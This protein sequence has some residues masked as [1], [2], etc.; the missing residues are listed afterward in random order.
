MNGILQPL[1]S[2]SQTTSPPPLASYSSKPY[3]F[4]YTFPSPFKFPTTCSSLACT[5]STTTITTKLTHLTT[6]A[7]SQ[8]QN[9]LYLLR[10]R[11]TEE[12]WELYSNLQHLPN[13]TCLS[14]LVSQLSFQ[15]TISGLKRAQSIVTRL[16]HERQLHRLDANCL[17]LLAVAASNAGHTLYAASVLKSMLRSGYLPNVKAW[18]AVVSRLTS[19]DDN[20]PA[21]ALRLFKGVTRRLRKLS[22]GGVVAAASMPDTAAFNA[23]LNACANLGDSNM[24]LQV[25]NEMPQY[26][27]VPDAFSYNIL[28][29][30]CC[31]TG[32]KHLLVYVLERILQ[33]GIP[34]C[35]TTLH[36]IV[37]SYVDLGDLETAE[38]LVQAM[39]EG[40]RDL[41]RIIREREREI[42]LNL[43]E[44]SESDDN[45]ADVDV[46]NA[47]AKLLPNFM[48]SNSCND[49]PV[50]PKAY[51][52]NTRMY[53][54]LM[55]GYMKA[56][57][58]TDTVRM[59]EAMRR[60]DDAGSHPDHV[61]YTTVVSA[62]V[63]AGYMD[64]ARQVLAEMM[65]IGVAANRITY[66]VLLKGYCNQF[67]I[68]KARELIKEMVDDRG[69]QPDVVSYNILID[70]CILVDDSAGALGFFNEMRTRGIAP[71]KIS[72]T[73]LM[74]AFAFSG[75]PKLAHK[76]FDEMLNDP[77]VKVDVIAWN[78]LV[79]G[80]CRLGLVEEAK[81]VI[82]K[83]KDEGFHPD[84]GTY[85]SFA[86]GIA[87]ARRPGEALL[88][89]NEV[90][91]RWEMV[92]KGSKHNSCVPPLKPDEGLLD[93]LAD[94]CVRAAFFRKALEIVACMEENGI[95]PNKTKFTR[96][97][98]EMHSRMFTSKHASRAR[99]DR[100]IERRR[101]AEAFKFWLG[102]PNSYYGSEWRL[103]PI[104]GYDDTAAS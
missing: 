8:D 37:A 103:E 46:E 23:V 98:V 79:E 9:L 93:T 50:L 39:R 78:M 65:R 64:R 27:V 16:R 61:S 99:Q 38:R 92:K 3:P 21:E 56:G 35:V 40:R 83:M 62:L 45:D 102:L 13:S 34:F 33:L 53:T 97:Y 14:R 63:K 19:S 6:T 82:Q 55:K 90:K 59:L 100:R 24:F 41:S 96:I 25:F 31:R 85:G 80:Y 12:A 74:K 5:P 36:C 18:S 4:P 7:E 49:L 43:E 32:R 42:E 104:E 30:L 44:L 73:T 57:R 70:G 22:S 89:W 52:P 2:S 77:R 81:K 95:S 72:Y 47:F 1:P 11:K 29:K 84:V 66:N 91:E 15:K 75:Q 71:T 17:G 58:V 60:Q 48:E 20:G 101:A 76:V 87:L 94:I 26:D 10:Q 28:M 51:A 69:I 88:L 68:D 54:T 67:Q 86:N